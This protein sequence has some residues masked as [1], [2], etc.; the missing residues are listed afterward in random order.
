MLIPICTQFH[1]AYGDSPYAKFSGS[2]HV[3]IW[4]LPVCVW[5]SVSDVSAIFPQV[6]RWIRNFTCVARWIRILQMHNM[7]T[8]CPKHDPYAYGD[9]DQSPYA[10][11]DQVNPHMHMGIACHAIPVCMY[12]DQN[13]S[14]YA[15]GDHRDPHMHTGITWHIIPVCIR[16]FVRSPYAYGDVS[17]ANHM[18]TGNISIWEIKSCIP[19]FVISHTGIAVCIWGSPYANVWGLLKSSHMGIPVCIMKLCT[20]G[21]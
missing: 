13:Q 20:Y 16:G 10:D 12:R 8:P 1:Y 7:R 19:I 9:Q 14:P 2:P 18:H 11:G 4:E 17:V 21:D 3:H 6:T 5:G 15:Y